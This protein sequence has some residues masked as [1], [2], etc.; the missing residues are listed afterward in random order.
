MG[1]VTVLNPS[2]A[3]TDKQN[4]LLR[5][6]VASDCNDMEFN[7][8]VNAAQHAGLDPFRRQIS[9]IVFSKDNAEKRKMALIVTIDGSRVIA[10]RTRQYRPDG[11]LPVYEIDTAL[12]SPSNPHGLVSCAVRVFKRDDSGEWFPCVGICYWDEFAPVKDEWIYSEE[13]KKR[14]PSGKLTVDGNWARMPRHML[15]KCAEQQALRRAFPDAFSGLYEESE[16]DKSRLADLAPSESVERYL[17]D[18]R[19]LRLGGPSILLA[20]EPNAELEAVPV[21][22]FADRVMAIIKDMRDL[23]QLEAF[24]RTNKEALKQFWAHNSGDA[25]ELNKKMETRANELNAT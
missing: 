5:Q 4:A 1:T 2:A 18:Q 24:K 19:A 21:G 6:T 14:V 9:A 22:G 13:K 7:L 11:E 12:K 8:F 20:P 3:Y 16:M 10:E 25:H 15:A 23:R 17:A